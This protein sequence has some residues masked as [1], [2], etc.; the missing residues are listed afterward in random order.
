MKEPY[1]ISDIELWKKKLLLWD[2]K[3]NLNSKESSLF[4][5]W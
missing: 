4:E 5:I 3:L 1:S 2:G